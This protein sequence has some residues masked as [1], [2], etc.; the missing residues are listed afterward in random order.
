MSTQPKEEKVNIFL[1][2]QNK[3]SSP[4][5]NRKLR[6][7]LSLASA[8]WAFEVIWSTRFNKKMSAVESLLKFQIDT[9][10]INILTTAKLREILR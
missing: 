9:I 2:L 4:C 10:I 5:K 1:L 3:V 7:P 6:A 8:S